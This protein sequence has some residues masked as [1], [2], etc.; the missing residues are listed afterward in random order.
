MHCVDDGFVGH[1]QAEAV[2]T[3]TGPI[4]LFKMKQ[5][6]SIRRTCG[7]YQCSTGSAMMPKSSPTEF[8]QTYHAAVDIQV[9]NPSYS[10]VAGDN[11]YFTHSPLCIANHNFYRLNNGIV[12]HI[13]YYYAS[14]SR[15]PCFST[16][17]DIGS[18]A[19]SKTS[20]IGLALLILLRIVATTPAECVPNISTDGR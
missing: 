5:R 19:V 2:H 9:N 13:K 10:I 1:L 18:Y 17:C 14:L 16:F 11:K 3:H 7:T 15:N 20:E 12:L 6:S 8:F 4:L